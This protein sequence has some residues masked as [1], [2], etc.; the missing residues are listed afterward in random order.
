M[1]ALVLLAQTTVLLISQRGFKKMKI[2]VIALL[3]VVG[4]VSGC[5]LQPYRP[6]SL[7]KNLTINLDLQSGGILTRT[8]AA[9][10][11]NNVGKDCSNDYK[12]YVDLAQGPNEIALAVGQRTL[13]I[14]E[15]TNRS[16]GSHNG[17]QR[18]VVLTPK[19]GVRYQ[20]DANY[21]DGMYDLRLYELTRAGKRPL[22]VGSEC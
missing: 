18:G 21:G 4:L 22:P 1:Q 17:M 15:I 13:V 12:G 8:S 6:G 3:L 19:P 11:I 10:G 20:L 16:V 9:A 7:E 5:G 14:V 2:H